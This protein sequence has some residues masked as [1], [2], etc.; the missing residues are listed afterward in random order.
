MINLKIDVDIQVNIMHKDTLLIGKYQ[1]YV[2]STMHQC[3]ILFGNFL[4][5]I[6]M[7]ATYM[8]SKKLCS[9]PNLV[10]EALKNPSW[11]THDRCTSH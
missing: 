7:V 6:N 9:S 8:W 4:L 2:Y 1:K 3:A 10:V 11:N 5:L